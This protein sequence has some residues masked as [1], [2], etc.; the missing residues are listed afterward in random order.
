MEKYIGTVF[1][2][3]LDNAELEQVSSEKNMRKI[4][5]AME[6]YKRQIKELEEHTVPTTPPEVIAQ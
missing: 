1:Q 5:Q 2:T 4:V 3:I 6:K